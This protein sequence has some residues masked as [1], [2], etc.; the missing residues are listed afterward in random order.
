MFRGGKPAR[1]ES[2]MEHDGHRERM[3]ERYRTQGL[4]SFAQHEIL[5]LMLFYAIPQRNVNPLAHQLI[6][7]FGSLYNVITATPEQL[8]QVRGVGDYTATLVSLFGDVYRKAEQ[9]R[10]AQR[11]KLTTRKAT[12]NYCIRLL[13]SEKRELFYAICLNGQM[14]TLGAV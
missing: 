3:R 9:T 6:T 4:D 1:E 2:G 5:E 7:H 8:A 10:A 11:E 13:E 14:E 12:V